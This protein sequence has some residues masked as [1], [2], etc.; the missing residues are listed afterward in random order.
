MGAVVNAMA[1]D[2]VNE[3]PKPGYTCR[4]IAFTGLFGEIVSMST[5][6]KEI[7]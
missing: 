7:G 6:E 4:K 3:Q 1:F 5:P 2:G